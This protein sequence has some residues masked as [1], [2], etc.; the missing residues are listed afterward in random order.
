MHALIAVVVLGSVTGQTWFPFPDIL[1]GGV[2]HIADL[3]AWLAFGEM[4]GP[5]ADMVLAVVYGMIAGQ[6]SLVVI[7]ATASQACRVTRLL[8]LVLSVPVACL[9]CAFVDESNQLAFLLELLCAP[10]AVLFAILGILRCLGYRLVART[11]L[12]V[13]SFGT[14]SL[15]QLLGFV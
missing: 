10:A 7:Y 13:P 3:A 15:F 2:R 14:Y 12:A 11:H 5:F 8:A 4:P 6:L 9:L 1:A